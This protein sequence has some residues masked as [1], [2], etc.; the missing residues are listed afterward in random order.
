V[1]FISLCLLLQCVIYQFMLVVTVCDSYEYFLEVV[2]N[3]VD[4]NVLN[5][6]HEPLART[7]CT[8][9]PAYTLCIALKGYA[10]GLIN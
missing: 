9:A 5:L 1:L 6:N 10:P 2:V 3:P 7:N 4:S 8:L